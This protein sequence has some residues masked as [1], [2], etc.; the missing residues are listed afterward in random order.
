MYNFLLILHSV[1]RWVII[2]LLVV[3]ILRFLSATVTN[4]VALSK[5]LLIAAHTTLLIG[6]YQYFAGGSGFALIQQYG[7]GE[8]MKDSAKRFWAVE[9]IT[10]MI[11]SIALITVGHI[12]LKKSGNSKRSAILY[13]LALAIILATVPWPFREGIGRPWLPGM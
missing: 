10:G 9:H 7:M 4:K 12:S 11:I 13:I 3:N 2:L 8:A 5:W 6:L 1:L